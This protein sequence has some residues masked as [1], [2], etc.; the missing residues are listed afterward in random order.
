MGTLAGVYNRGVIMGGLTSAPSSTE[1]LTVDSSGNM[2]R[3]SIPS[4]SVVPFLMQ[5]RLTLATGTPVTTSDLTSQSTLYYTPFCGSVVTTYSGSAWVNSILTEKS[6]ALSGLTSGK[7]YDVFLYDNAGTLTLELSAAWTNDTTRADALT[8]QNGIY[9]K[10]GATTRVYLGTF[11][12]TSTTATEDSCANR[13][14]F[15]AYNQVHRKVKITDTTDS[16]TYASTTIRQARATA[17]NQIAIV[18]GLDYGMVVD[19]TALA[20]STGTGPDSFVGIGYNSTTANSADI[21]ASAP[22]STAILTAMAKI[23][24]NP[25]IG[26]HYYAWL[27]WNSTSSTRTY[28]G[29]RG[30]ANTAVQSG[31]FGTVVI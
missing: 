6:L 30:L 8:T 13:F 26:Y 21:A 17:T 1:M 14:L 20:M 29:D 28:Y 18:N 7:N 5:G 9:V 16:W 27:E 25:G 3:Q 23:G 4:S 12:T 19:I 10:S 2:G 31:L 24:H 22:T 11:R 15:N